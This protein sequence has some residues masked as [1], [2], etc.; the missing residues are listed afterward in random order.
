MDKTAAT[1]ES[2]MVAENP[3]TKNIILFHP[4][5]VLGSITYQPQITSV[6]SLDE[7]PTTNVP[8][9]IANMVLFRTN[10][11]FLML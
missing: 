4:C 1:T 10:K 7:Q 11:P 3:L 6:V 8:K 9:S 5:C 2:R